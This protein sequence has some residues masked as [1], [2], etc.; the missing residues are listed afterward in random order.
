MAC[1]QNSQPK[2][3]AIRTSAAA[4]FGQA[5][6]LRRC[7]YPCRKFRPPILAA[8]AGSFNFR[9]LRQ[10]VRT[11]AQVN[12]LIFC[13]KISRRNRRFNKDRRFRP[14]SL[15][16]PQELHIKF[17]EHAVSVLNDV[18]FSFL[19]V[20]SGCFYFCFGAIFF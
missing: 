6:R 15:P 18:V 2:N 5:E 11:S 7:S 16:Q 13:K 19:S 8:T 20:F 4:P 17:K 3:Q 9:G 14:L 1:S 12:K 10:G